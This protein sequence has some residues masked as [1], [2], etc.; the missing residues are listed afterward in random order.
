M[1][2]LGVRVLRLVFAASIVGGP[3]PLL[4]QVRSPVQDLLATAR[5]ALNDLRYTD[6]DS[7]AQAVL[8]LGSVRRAERIQALQ[9][10]AGAAFPE[11]EPAQQR[12]R[13]L[14][15]L[16]RLVRIAPTST[17]P[18]EV[19][20]P[21]LEALL[22]EAHRTTFG[23]SA[24]PR[25][26]YVLTGPDEQVEIEVVSSRPARFALWLEPEAGGARIPLDSLP[27]LPRGTLRFQVLSHGAPKLQ[28][29][30]GRLVVTA[31]DASA[32]DTISFS[33]QA[34]IEAPGLQYETIP[35]QLP[36]AALLPE[37]TKPNR[38]LGVLGGALALLGTVV[39]SRALRDHELKSS[40]GGDSRAVGLGLVLGIGTAG[41]VLLLDKGEVLP[42][43]IKANADT[44]AHFAQSV[45]EAHARNAA[46]LRSYRAEMTINPEPRP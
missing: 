12:N 10:V 14:D 18:R 25:D 39:V 34:R 33:Y 29:G 22:Q 21:G 27:P 28:S 42:A 3:G 11:Q 19:S 38:A 1:T 32:P 45:S 26:R 40:A 15:A 23:A 13:A 6:A 4:A 20:W 16:R 44:R 35:D 2:P 37:V 43:S 9:L 17:L 41:G 36:V 31:V 24:A 5:T 30:A 46:L 7:I 8:S